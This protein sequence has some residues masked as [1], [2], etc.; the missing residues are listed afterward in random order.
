[1]TR[2]LDSHPNICTLPEDEDEKVSLASLAP[3]DKRY[4]YIMMDSGAS[5]HAADLD[6]HFPG[7][8]LEET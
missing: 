8:E 2:L 7:H 6:V 3:R 1:M 4:V 5:L